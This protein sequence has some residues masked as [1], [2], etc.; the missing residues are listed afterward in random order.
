MNISS[1]MSI[2][3]RIIYF[4]NAATSFPKPPEVIDAVVRYLTQTGANPGRSGHKLAVEAGRI[5]FNTR[6]KLAALFGISNPMRVI[7]TANATSALNLAIQGI[8][9][10]GDHFITTSMEHNSTIRPLRELQKKGL[11]TLTIIQANKLG[12]IDPDKI[13]RAIRKN[14]RA[15]VINHASNLTGIVQPVQNITEICKQNRIITV[16]D[17]AQSAGT[18]P[19]NLQTDKI[20]LLGLAGHKGLLGPTGTGAL[21][22]S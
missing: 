19:L 6:Q 12:L 13:T 11:I 22:I 21:L 4:D 10:E 14:T 8:A 17:A 2:D 18:I 9:R 3:N 5:V 20:D 1:I 16:I 15:C 7:F